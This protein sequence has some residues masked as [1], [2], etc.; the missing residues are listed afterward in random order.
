[1]TDLA[2][3]QAFNQVYAQRMPAVRTVVQAV[4]LPRRGRDVGGEATLAIRRAGSGRS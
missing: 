2:E 4:L 1:M 3:W